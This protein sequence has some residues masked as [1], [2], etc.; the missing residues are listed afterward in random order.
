MA[1]SE[2][3]A[4]S[5][6]TASTVWADMTLKPNQPTVRV[7]APIDEEGDGGR[8]VGGHAAVGA[9]A[10]LAGPEQQ[11]GGE[12]DPAAHGVDHDGAGEVVEGRAEESPSMSDWSPKLPFQTMPSKKG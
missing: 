5:P 8:R 3:T 10:P 2:F 12:P 1:I 7:Q 6:L 11:H 4:T 9:V